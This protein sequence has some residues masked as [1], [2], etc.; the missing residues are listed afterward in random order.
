MEDLSSQL[1]YGEDAAKEGIPRARASV[2]HLRE[3]NPYVDVRV[4]T[5]REGGVVSR[6]GEQRSLV[7]V[8]VLVLG[9]CCRW[10]AGASPFWVVFVELFVH[11]IVSTCGRFGA[12]LK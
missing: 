8:L 7:V 3:L 4:L 12:A 2:D 6:G 9:T 1:C 10:S 5:V 11:R